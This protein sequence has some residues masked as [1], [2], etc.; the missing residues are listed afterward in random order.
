M[1]NLFFNIDQL[2]RHLMLILMVMF[3]A[4]GASAQLS[5]PSFHPEDMVTIPKSPEASS[6]RQYGNAD[7]NL[8]TGTA[9][10]SIP[11]ASL[12][13]RKIGHDVS[14]TYVTSGI[15]VEQQ[16]SQ[17]GLGWNLNAGGFVS[18]NVNGLPDDYNSAYWEY[19]PFYS[20]EISPTETDNSMPAPHW[21]V[22]QLYAEFRDKNY[23]ENTY[24]SDVD[25][26][27][28]YLHFRNATQE[29]KMLEIQ[30]DTYSFSAGGFAGTLYIT[31]YTTGAAACIE[32]PGI[33]AQAIFGNPKPGE[34]TG[35]SRPIT[36]WAVTDLSG[37][38]YRFELAEV[39]K[40]EG[41]EWATNRE[42]NSGWYL[43][44]ITAYGNTDVIDFV[45]GS[46]NGSNPY[47]TVTW[48]LPGRTGFIRDQPDGINTPCGGA[49]QYQESAGLRY[50]FFKYNLEAIRVN[51]LERVDFIYD[52]NR[53]DVNINYDL[54]E[55]PGPHNNEPLLDRVVVKDLEGVIS[56]VDLV[57]S[58]FG[59]DP[60]STLY[61]SRLKLDSV[62]MYG[63]TGKGEFEA[64]SFSYNESVPMPSRISM[65]MDYW[66]YYNGQSNSTLI[67]AK[68][69][70]DDV[71]AGTAN[72]EPNPGVMEVGILTSVTYPTGGK[73]EFDYK[74]NARVHYQANAIDQSIASVGLTGGS[75]APGVD[76]HN[77]AAC[78]P[79]FVQAPREESA[80]FFIAPG[81]EGEYN[82][83]VLVNGVQ[84][85]NGIHL[86]AFYAGSKQDYCDLTGNPGGVHYQEGFI[87]SQAFTQ[88]LNANTFY[89]LTV[90]N[91][92]PT[93]N[94][95]ITISKTITSSVPITDYIG[96]LRL[97][98]QKNFVQDSVLATTTYYYYD[99]ISS[100]DV[101]TISENTFLNHNSE[102]AI[103]H[104]KAVFEKPYNSVVYTQA[105]E[106]QPGF[107]QACEFL[108]R[109]AS[110]QATPT[111]NIITY[112]VASTVQMDTVGNINGALVE[113]YYNQDE[114]VGDRPFAKTEI[115]NGRLYQSTSYKI[116]G[117]S[118][119]PLQRQ[120]EH[121]SYHQ[122][123]TAPAI[124]GF[125]FA[126]NSSDYVNQLIMKHPD[127]DDPASQSYQM[128]A[129]VYYSQDIQGVGDNYAPA[130]CN[131][132]ETN[133]TASI[134]DCLYPRNS[135]ITKYFQQP[136][137]LY[138]RWLKKDSTEVFAYESNGN[139]Q[140]TYHYAYTNLDH[141]Q[142]TEQLRELSDEVDERITFTYPHEENLTS[143]ISRNNLSQ[144]VRTIREVNGVS[145]N[146]KLSDYMQSGTG[147]TLLW[148]E[149][150][151]FRNGSG[152]LESRTKVVDY[153]AY[154]NIETMVG[155]D[156]IP[157]TFIWG[158]NSRFIVAHFVG[159][160]KTDI[161]AQ[162][163]NGLIFDA[164]GGHAFSEN[165]HNVLRDAFPHVQVSTYT[166]DPGVGM[167]RQTEPNGFS[168][169][170]RYDK[171]S[172]L[173]KVED[174]D[175]NVLTEYKYHLAASQ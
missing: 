74:A 157:Q 165:R 159:I 153:D 133:V 99:D 82:V 3:S 106:N 142:V 27:R 71:L 145:V 122:G 58:Y 103:V 105:S 21:Q 110:N 11:V 171:F 146:E 160:T 32:H 34:A 47:E 108:D 150:V 141:Y 25:M 45:Y 35:G 64:Y 66:G 102:S 20:S 121:Y 85:A 14:L 55:D 93:L 90:V 44:E 72:R 111:P 86:V 95:S 151:L 7:V 112:G 139:S 107:Y 175:G 154:G 33:I 73:T 87:Q 80:Q 68:P 63:S 156:G 81:E 70:Y 42:Y 115:L 50:Q 98:S 29:T 61:T 40:V 65:G 12:Q 172:R 36:G 130:A 162:M 83:R 148:P 31:D 4:L 52:Y 18:R 79:D 92:D 67:P 39:T 168:T 164:E 23:G 113:K 46:P 161:L 173:I 101:N 54:P 147:L 170:F 131:Y 2:G 89:Q 127:Y 144:V 26:L 76:N 94:L 1:K 48:D 30:P 126:S 84:N 13:G 53:K 137:G 123:V 77:Y 49:G 134:I 75:Y 69:G 6:F 167:T 91:S 104:H 41:T 174:R 125:Y 15:K 9:N 16:A 128:A 117:N 17:A 136:Y 51:G 19:Y 124:T 5:G 169:F 152:P 138:S 109:F 38:T 10:V 120:T 24:H 114:G 28:R 118:L 57:Q 43:T 88:H 132:T 97:I 37:N 59:A 116:D 119:I 129:H 155:A 149:E 96:G 8:Y 62:K 166:Y 163:P 135:T 100:L 158:Y 78:E 140:Q 143:L 60:P 22:N 56:V